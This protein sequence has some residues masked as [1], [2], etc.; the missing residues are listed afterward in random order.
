MS[1]FLIADDH[2]LFREALQAALAP[3]FDDLRVIEADSL[4]NTLKAIKNH[5]DIDLILLD[6]NM[7][8][9]ENYYGL[10]SVLENSP[11]TP[12]LVVSASDNLESVNV[13]MHYGA[14]GFIPKSYSSRK[15][16]HA[17]MSVLEGSKFI[18]EKYIDS[19]GL[20]K[21]DMLQSI[22]CVRDLTPKQ[23]RVLKC[24]K[25]GKMNKQI[26]DEL[27]VTEATVKAHISAIFKKFNVTSRT[28]VVLLV[29]KL[30]LDD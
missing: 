5:S 13:V 16:A 9:A 8:G 22:E 12:I 28:Q 26:A 27:F 3:F 24:L 17:I 29:D 6:L 10:T 19:I 15:M 20:H 18:P 2:P 11:D 21:P 7:P 25:Q 14:K 30:E 1:T 23:L 4:Q